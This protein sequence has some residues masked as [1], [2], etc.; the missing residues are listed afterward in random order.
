MMSHEGMDSLREKVTALYCRS[1]LKDGAA[2]AEQKEILLKHSQE[3]GYEN[4]EFYCDDGHSGMD[5]DGTELAK[6]R[7]DIADG[8]V[9]RVV[10]KDVSRLGRDVVSTMALLN[11][12]KNCGVSFDFLDGTKIDDLLHPLAGFPKANEVL[13]PSFRRIQDPER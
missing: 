1:A 13:K 4:I 6:L 9:E 5:C 3:R 8:L 10:A 7:T 2:I 11:D 12:M